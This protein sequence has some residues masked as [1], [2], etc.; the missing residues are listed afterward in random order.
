MDLKNIE[1]QTNLDSKQEIF[2]YTQQRFNL[3][4]LFL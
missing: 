4:R 1:M 3:R 2:F